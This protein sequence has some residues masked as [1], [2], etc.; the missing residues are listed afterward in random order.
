MGWSG[1]WL[2]L[3]CVAVVVIVGCDG[4]GLEERRGDERRGDERRR[5]AWN[6]MVCPSPF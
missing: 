2:W 6:S 1:L 5:V 3:G 4:I